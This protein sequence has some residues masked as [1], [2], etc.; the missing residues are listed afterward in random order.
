MALIVTIK[1]RLH[2]KYKISTS[3]RLKLLEGSSS[4]AAHP[5]VYV[6]S[7][8]LF[9][10]NTGVMLLRIQSYNSTTGTWKHWRWI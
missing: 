1:V 6:V 10:F 2:D 9:S 5:L 3:N 7:V 4:A 8:T